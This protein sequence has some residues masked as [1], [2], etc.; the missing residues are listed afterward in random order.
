MRRL[1]AGWRRVLRAILRNPPPLLHSDVLVSMPGRVADRSRRCTNES[2]ENYAK[3][4][5]TK[6]DRPPLIANHY[7][8]G[9]NCTVTPVRTSGD[10]RDFIKMVW[11]I[12]HDDPN[13]V[14]P[15]IADRRKLLDRKR[16]PFYKHAE[17][18]MFVARDG[19][20]T[21]GRIAAIVNHSHNQTHNDTVGFF[22]FFESIDDQ[23]VADALFD[24][25]ERWLAARGLTVMRGPV[26]PSLNDEAGLLVDGF[27]DPPQILM[28]YNPNYYSRLMETHGFR[29]AK[30]LYAYRLTR[31][32]FLNPKLERVQRMVRER[33]GLTIR[34]ANLKQKEAFRRDVATLKSI[35]NAAWEPNWGFVKMTDEEFDF[36][37]A[38]LKQVALADLVV[39]VER[40]G[41]PIGFA[42]ALPDINQALIY[43]R[44]GGLL[45][46]LWC[47]LFKRAKITRGRIVVLG[48]VPA[49]QRLGI[50]AVLYFEIGT[51]MTQG[52]SYVEGEASWVLED[53]TMMN[54]AAEM[55]NGEIYKRYRIYDKTVNKN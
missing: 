29:K 7:L 48:V 12:Y 21:V 30:D 52:R 28:T 46:A 37:A 35:Y 49:F 53:N 4:E 22:G 2:N 32:G 15:I 51:R 27:D 39:F 14:P 44:R 1:A 26:N 34:S 43:N 13:W 38:D 25:A 11:R 24:A 18:E 20:Q 33:E 23:S 19:R 42:L 8:R 5:R 36:L 9:M 10:L 40:K 16:N 47:L 50:D 55:M 31:G 6:Q 54:R 45:G 3:Q 17:M 41:E